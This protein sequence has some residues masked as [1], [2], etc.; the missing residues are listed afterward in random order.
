MIRNCL[1]A[2]KL[3]LPDGEDVL[4]QPHFLKMLEKNTDFI[5]NGKLRS[6]KEERSASPQR[7]IKDTSTQKHSA[8][9]TH[10]L[11]RPE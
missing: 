4:I 1:E 11:S 10:Q 5:M 8:A 7:A 2:R 9:Q 6:K 3:D